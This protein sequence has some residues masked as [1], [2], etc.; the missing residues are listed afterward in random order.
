MDP[1]EHKDKIITI[2]SMFYPEAK[3]YLF[4]SYARGDATR[5]SDLDIAI[6][7]KEKISIITREQIKSMIDALNLLQTVDVVDFQRVPK[8]MQDNI[9]KE[10]ILWKN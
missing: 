4:G 6:D 5:A 1:I 9:L 8:T 3:I 2:I 7:N 10:G